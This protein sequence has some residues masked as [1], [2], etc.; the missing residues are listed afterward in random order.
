[1][2]ERTAVYRLYNTNGEL[3]YVGISS[4]P[5]ARWMQHLATKDW[6]RDVSRFSIEWHESRK[7]AA[8]AELTAIADERPLHNIAGA[9][10]KGDLGTR[11]VKLRRTVGKTPNVPIRID[12][13]LWEAFGDVVGKGKRSAAI[14]AFIRSVV[15]AAE[16]DE[17]PVA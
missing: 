15:E 9:L 10:W 17:R 12:A 16:D 4:R 11:G 3:L 8:D 5:E 13:D 7:L 14:R 1:M 6:W 2:S